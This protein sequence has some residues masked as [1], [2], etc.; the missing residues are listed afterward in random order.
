MK[1]LCNFAPRESSWTCI[2]TFLI[3]WICCGQ[4]FSN[5]IVIRQNKHS[6]RGNYI[7]ILDLQGCDI[8]TLH[9]SLFPSDNSSTFSFKL[10]NRIYSVLIKDSSW[11]FETTQYNKHKWNNKPRPLRRH[12]IIAL[13]AHFHVLCFR[14]N[15]DF[16]LHVLNRSAVKWRRHLL[17]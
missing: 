1:L 4:L 3:E 11:T 2:T 10:T 16:N 5:G 15:V 6:P 7:I 12:C 17:S 8:V 14:Q 13:F 9:V